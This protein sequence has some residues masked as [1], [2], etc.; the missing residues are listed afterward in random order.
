[1]VS[2]NLTT[3][4]TDVTHLLAMQTGGSIK[5]G[6]TAALAQIVGQ[7][8]RA[9][10]PSALGAL[11]TG[12]DGAVLHETGG[13]RFDTAQAKA[14]AQ[15]AM[16]TGRVQLAGDGLTIASPSQFG[17]NG[18][19]VGVVVT[20]W[21]EQFILA[22]LADS[23]RRTL[24]LSFTVFIC[25]MVLMALFLSHY[26]SRPLARI[27]MA[28]KRVAKGDYDTGV[29]FTERKDEIGRMARRL[30]HFRQTLGHAKEAQRDAAFK[31]AAFEGSSAMMMMAD[32]RFVV[33]FANPACASFWDIAARALSLNEANSAQGW[34]GMRLG[35]IPDLQAVIARVAEG[36]ACALPA[37]VHMRLGDRHMRINLNA[38]LDERGQMIGTVIE[39]IDGTESQHNAAVLKAIDVGQVRLEFD[40]DGTCLLANPIAQRVLG[41]PT[42]P[43]ALHQLT[44]NTI[45]DALHENGSSQETLVS[46]AMAGASLKGLFEARNEGA[47]TVHVIDGAFA[48]VLDPRG[49]PERSLF[50]GTDVTQARA[51]IADVEAER[52]RV[53]SEQERVVTALGEALR[54]LS[55][56]DL[57]AEIGAAF[58][59]DYEPLR[60]NYNA[61]VV[62]LRTAVAAVMRNAESIRVEAS[63]ITNAADDLSRRTERQAA[64]L[65]E[66]AAALDELTTSVR[67][68]AR[69]ADAA[70]ATSAE[71]QRN[72]EQGGAVARSAMTAMDAI[73]DSSEEISK[74][75]SVIDD[76]A[77]QTNLLALN[78]GVEAARAGEAGRGFAVVAT[79]V[80]AL[81]QRSSDAA[82]EINTLITA[83]EEQVREGVD[84]VERTGTALSAIVR[85][86]ADISD[87]VAA[88][89][90]S[91]R[92]QSN[93]L[94][95]VNTAVTELDQ[96]TQ[97]NSAM[98]E[99]TTAASH[100]LTEE[101]DGL[102]AAVGTF[103]LGDQVAVKK[104]PAR[105]PRV[106]L[107][108]GATALAVPD[109]A[110]EDSDGWEEF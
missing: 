37:T 8:I 88:I 18:A 6:N 78:A 91:A 16:D 2:H 23:E 95:E 43:D 63:D 38:A 41:L 68:A 60:S 48:A 19:H 14:L 105:R 49:R 110:A 34:V 15:A 66:T 75:T 52:R 5:F 13:S 79:E 21:T 106:P 29:P 42:D 94:G 33:T 71:A 103:T 32:E 98:F 26:M 10:A 28:M 64:T 35:D 56:G 97:Q 81:A 54:C 83:S 72:A 39:W 24:A 58:P 50:L 69:S 25:A 96:V 30:D 7:T 73:K 3:R 87:K 92:E 4:A 86:V 70:S 108:V 59:A 67:S 53:A 107:T 12:P 100:A 89:A 31:S 51:D 55:D 17:P 84:L 93:G 85:S 102:A 109:I 44:V 27:E 82:R 61:A 47:G 57:T 11:V 101:A 45:F 74:I 104:E 65:E 1:M 99:Q 46:D 20:S 90:V 76:I 77:F 80:R 40:A 36:G 22:E 9:A 62:G